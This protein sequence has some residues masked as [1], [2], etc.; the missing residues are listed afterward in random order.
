[1]SRGRQLL[2]DCVQRSF[3]A[4]HQRGAAGGPQ[5]GG[6]WAFRAQD[7]GP[8]HQPLRASRPK[9]AGPCPEVIR[10]AGPKSSDPAPLKQGHASPQRGGV[11]DCKS[12]TQ[13]LTE[14]EKE[15]GGR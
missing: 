4:G 13:Q 3:R 11:P 8:G 7:V 15:R 10:P 14:K 2:V 12:G 6:R 1:M 9:E 5:E